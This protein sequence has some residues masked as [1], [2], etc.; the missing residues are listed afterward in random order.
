MMKI[1]QIKKQKSFPILDTVPPMIATLDK[2]TKLRIIGQEGNILK[3]IVIS[4]NPAEKR[5]VIA[6]DSQLQKEGVFIL[7]KRKRDIKLGQER[8]Y[9]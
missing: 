8:G 5:E 7:R 2:G 6:I 1:M 4:G 9:S 3:C